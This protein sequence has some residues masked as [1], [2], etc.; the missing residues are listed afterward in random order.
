MPALEKEL[1]DLVADAVVIPNRDPLDKYC[2]EN[3]FLPS[4]PFNPSGYLDLHKSKYL[5]EP[6]LALQDSEVHEVVAVGPPRSGKTL[7]GQGYLLYV[8]NE[9]PADILFAVHKKDTIKAFTDVRLLPLFHANKIQFAD[10]TLLGGKASVTQR[11]IKFPVG[12]LKMCGAQTA[13][14]FT[15]LGHRVL[16]G[17][18]L[19]KWQAGMLDQF[20]RRADDFRYTKKILLISQASEHDTDFH[21]EYLQGNQAVWGSSVQSAARIKFIISHTKGPMGN[22]RGFALM[23]LRTSGTNGMYPPQRQR[24]GMNAFTVSR[25]SVIQRTDTP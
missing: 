2:L 16:I 14:D 1:L 21:K 5:V 13:G 4:P 25:S 24:L 6:M 11:F 18:E 9:E 8:I 3:I 23:R 22:M 20:K 7:L 15:Q 19:W 17:D 10:E 12:S